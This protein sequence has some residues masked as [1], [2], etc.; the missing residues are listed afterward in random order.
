MFSITW[1]LVLLWG[2]ANFMWHFLPQ[3]LQIGPCQLPFSLIRMLESFWQ[4]FFCLWPI[5]HFLLGFWLELNSLLSYCSNLTNL[6]R[7]S[8]RDL[9]FPIIFFLS[10]SNLSL[11]LFKEASF[12]LKETLSS[13]KALTML[14]WKGFMGL[15][16]KKSKT[17]FSSNWDSR[18]DLEE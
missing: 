9:H 16:Q 4:R 6:V 11:E 15:T 8:L 5:P 1:G 13:I 7:V 17:Y 10:F 3:Y 2:H 14:S 18:S 12:V